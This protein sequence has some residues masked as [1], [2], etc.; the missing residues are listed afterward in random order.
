[1]SPLSSVKTWRPV[2]LALG[3]GFAVASSLGPNPVVGSP[4]TQDF[5]FKKIVDTT[6]PIPEGVG[7]FTGFPS[8]VVAGDDVAILASGVNDQQGFYLA[9]AGAL[10]RI[11]D[12]E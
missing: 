11:A 4:P 10:I 9:H 12:L 8:A 3:L 6:S 5:Q 2:A 7:N 1:M